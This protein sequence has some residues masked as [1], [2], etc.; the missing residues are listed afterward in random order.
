MTTNCWQ[1]GIGLSWFINRHAFLNASYEWEELETNVPGDGYE[2]NSV[3]L[4][5]G[6]E[7]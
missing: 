6:L 5:L 3:W 7:Y 1:A 2:T 4:V